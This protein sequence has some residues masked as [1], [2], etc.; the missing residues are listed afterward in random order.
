M[1]RKE[2]LSKILELISTYE[3][4]TQEELTDKLLNEGLDV[5]QST[6]SRDIKD[7][8]LIKVEGVNKKFKY[9]KA[10]LSQNNI[11][12]RTINLFKQTTI[13]IEC[14]NNLIVLKTLSGN[15]GTAGMAID[16]MNFPQVL[17][18]IAGDD[19]VLIIAKT[20]SDAEIILKSLRT[21]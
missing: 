20:N 12:E 2:R 5:S 10:V 7:L 17:G 15:A 16:E 1:N 9:T 13:S 4:S 6:V 19:T 21:L 3:V 8:N 18:T 11:S 14:A